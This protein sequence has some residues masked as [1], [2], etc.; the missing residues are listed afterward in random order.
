LYLVPVTTAIAL[1]ALLVMLSASD[2]EAAD[3]ANWTF[4]RF[5]HI[6]AIGDGTHL[7]LINTWGDIRTRDAG[8]DQIEIV[9]NIQTH[10]DDDQALAV[11]IEPTETGFR[12]HATRAGAASDDGGDDDA[13]KLR[14]RLDLTV[15]VPAGVDVSARTTAGLLELKGVDGDVAG[16]TTDGRIVL[17]TS[18]RARLT[19]DNGDIQALFKST[20]WTGASEFRSVNGEIAVWLP[21]DASVTALGATSGQITTDY[22]MEIERQEVS[23]RKALRAVVGEGRA[24]LRLDSER[25]PVKLLRSH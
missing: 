24:A 12:I 10:V 2:L 7:E 25:G 5:H 3:D 22:T 19:T 23:A 13:Q 18:G 4:D 20:D 11:R 6:E 14:G 17:S 9:A 1:T 21:P 8:D 15:L 16:T